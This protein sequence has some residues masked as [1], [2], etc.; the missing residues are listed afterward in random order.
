MRKTLYS[1]QVR[2]MSQPQGMTMVKLLMED[3]RNE[4]EDMTFNMAALE[5]KHT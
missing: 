1:V 5:G 3:W 4:S 2:V